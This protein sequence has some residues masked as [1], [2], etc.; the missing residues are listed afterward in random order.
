MNTDKKYNGWNNYETWC[1]ALW[2]GNDEY[3]YNLC[4]KEYTQE[5]IERSADK[6]SAVDTLAEM[7]KTYIDNNNPLTLSN[8]CSVYSDLLTTALSEVDYE[9]IAT[10]YVDDY[11]QNNNDVTT[12]WEQSA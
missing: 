5:A 12:H 2:I 6:S 7:L 4:E 1:V 11:L 3:S 9:E 8:S 10:N